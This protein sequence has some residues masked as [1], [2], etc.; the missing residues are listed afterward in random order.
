M[1]VPATAEDTCQCP[2][3][4]RTLNPRIKSPQAES[5]NP[6]KHRADDTT[7][8]QSPPV[9]HG[10]APDANAAGDPTAAAIV[11]ALEHIPAEERAAILDHLRAL[12]AMTP[13]RRAA[14]LTLT[15]S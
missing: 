8:T 15:A 2:P 13:K 12:A 6:G 1:E 14:L 11:E 5:E 3:R 7:P 10:E 9:E 4:T